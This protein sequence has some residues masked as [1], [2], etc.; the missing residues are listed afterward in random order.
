MARPWCS[1]L[2][3][4]SLFKAMIN[5]DVLQQNLINR[6]HWE[7][8]RNSQRSL[9]QPTSLL[10]ASPRIY[11]HNCPAKCSPLSHRLS[12]THARYVSSPSPIV[13]SLPSDCFQ[14]GLSICWLPIRLD[15]NHIFCIRCMIK[16]QNRGK[17]SCPLCRAETIQ[18]ATEGASK[19]CFRPATATALAGWLPS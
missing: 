7:S 18:Q 19:P 17:R 14:T 8:S 2:R 16:M 15:C 3:A 13:I 5:A 10:R 6:P 11:A 1:L 12:T 4:D 9:D